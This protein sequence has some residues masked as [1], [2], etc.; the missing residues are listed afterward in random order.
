MESPE[1]APT[2]SSP[3]TNDATSRRRSGRAKYQPVLFQED[4]NIPQSSSSTGKRK[5]TQLRGDDRGAENSTSDEEE[6]P[7]PE[8]DPDEEELKE[9]RRKTT[10]A[11]K[12]S[13]KPA[14]KKVKTNGATTKLAVRPASNGFKKPAPPKKSRARP[15]PAVME[16]ESGL[17]GKSLL[18]LTAKRS[19]TDALSS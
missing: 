16:E 9:K 8:S 19:A 6:S 11:K 3:A 2:S 15:N 13:G 5:R 10:K 18:S 12:P 4:P 7:E 1:Q 17:Y 14:A